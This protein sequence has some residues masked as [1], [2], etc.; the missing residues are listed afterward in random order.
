MLNCKHCKD[1]LNKKYQ[2]VTAMTLYSAFIEVQETV[3]CFFVCHEMEEVPRK[4][5]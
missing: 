1:I 5:K 3:G 2:V 4:I